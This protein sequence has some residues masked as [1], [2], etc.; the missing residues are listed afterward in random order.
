M[1]RLADRGIIELRGD[2]IS[3]FLN[4]LLTK[5]VD[6]ATE[7]ILT[8]AALLGPQGKFL[9]DLFV[10]RPSSDTFLIDTNH[11]EELFQKLRLYKM[12]LPIEISVREDLAVFAH[13]NQIE[14]SFPDPRNTNLGFRVFAPKEAKTDGEFE[15]YENKR[16]ELGIPDPSR[17]LIRDGD[18]ALEG[19]LDEMGAIDFQK[20]CFIGQEMTSR[21]K[22]RGTLKQKLV[23]I[24]INGETP[25][26]DTSILANET[27]I[28]R[29]RTNNGTI[30]LALMRIDRAKIALEN[31]TKTLAGRAEILID[32][33]ETQ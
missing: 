19:L 13:F 28:G 25:E 4:N 27:E 17:D 33:T 5:N 31:G 14:N 24:R 26:F 12:R 1:I 11:C 22:R 30:G 32:A 8:Y 21:M 9:F 2:T 7:T 20:G 16:F 18:F 10:L 6:I 3:P 15:E 29:I 23:K